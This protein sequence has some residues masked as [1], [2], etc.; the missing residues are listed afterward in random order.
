MKAEYELLKDSDIDP[1]L[2]KIAENFGTT[3]KTL[4]DDVTKIISVPSRIRI[5]QRVDDTKYVLRVRGASDEDITFLTGILGDPIKVSQEKLSL[6]DFVKIVMSIPDVKTKS[7][8]EVIDILDLSDEEFQG[9]FKQLE[10]FGKR[11]RGPQEILDIY[12]L[13][14][15]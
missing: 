14:S 15:K 8:D 11:G 12:E 4:E 9:Y 10:R 1:L 2:E 7:K 3:V 13:L 6:N 5:L